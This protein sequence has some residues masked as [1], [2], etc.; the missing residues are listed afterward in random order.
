LV[1]GVGLSEDDNK[2]LDPKNWVGENLLG[3]ILVDVRE[4]LIELEK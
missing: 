1:W 3:K 2:I 4:S